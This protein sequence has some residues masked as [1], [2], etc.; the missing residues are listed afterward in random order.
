MR[1]LPVCEWLLF[2]LLAGM[3]TVSTLPGA[4]FKLNTDF[5]NYFLTASLVHEHYDTSRIYEWQW[6]E[7]QKDHRG[8]DQ[9]IVGMVPITPF[10]T[11]VVYPLT[12]F[13]ALT[14]KHC[15]IVFNLGLLVAAMYFLRS[16][17]ALPW[18]RIALLAAMNHTLAINFEYGQFYVLLLFLI[19]LACWCHVRQK[20]WWSGLLIGLATGI[21]IFP[22]IFLVYFLRKKDWRAFTGGVIGAASTGAV[23][24]MVFG[25][26][27]HRTYL[28]Q[29]LPPVLRGE[30]L[31]PYHLGAES[32]SSLLHRLFVYEP[33]SNP[34][35]ALHAAWMFAVLH[36]LLQMALAAP[37][38][39]LAVPGD[40][41]PRRVGLEWV[42]LLM[43]SLVTSTSPGDYLF[44]LLLFPACVLLERLL[45]LRAYWWVLAV[46]LLYAT[47]GYA[48]GTN[49][50]R[51]G[52][53]ALLGVPRLHALVALAVI[54]Y[55]MQRWLQRSEPGPVQHGPVQSGSTFAWAVA[56]GVVLVFSVVSN[57]RHQRGLYADYA[58]RIAAP[59]DVFLMAAPTVDG[60]AVGFVAMMGTGYHSVIQ[61]PG[62]TS[63]SE[64]S[65]DDVLG[66]TAAQGKWWVEQV[67]RESSV[68]AGPFPAST[69][70]QAEHP[71]ASAAGHWLAYLRED[72]GRAQVLRRDLQQP[73][74][75]DAVITPP[76]LNVTEMSLT[77]D[78]GLVFSAT[79]GGRT[80]LYF[81]DG[82]GSVRA[83][84]VNDTRYP[85]VS[86]DGHW[87]AYSELHGGN[88]NLWLR[89]LSSGEERR[90]TEAPCNQMESAWSSDSKSL[91]YASDCGRGL[92][93]TMLCK[94]RVV[95]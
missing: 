59:K 22:G 95:P 7:R 68:I 73:S 82:G 52:W 87:L 92:W 79:D 85:A 39:L 32:L 49:V 33:Y 83:M 1:W 86:P 60:D 53:L 64:V 91:I 76:Q 89:D 63:L 43:A 42:T 54:A 84:N 19:V 44:T 66:T 65:D 90:L 58:L 28:T 47:A 93:F 11:L 61:R 14:A 15:W 3:M 38:L 88:W 30:G 78:G 36:P 50:G 5:P 72:H 20:S 62:E 80:A 46:T 8:L 56:L 13:A 4:W 29:V 2:A 94:R 35:P 75:M 51:D 37:A 21:K 45:E 34:H 70:P 9:R 48:G 16:L 57:V 25:W 41:R 24:V 18:R 81:A 23:S 69:I 55:A 77:P 27:L 31:D 71:I 74:S 10:S 67:G 40:T 12:G 6:I 17:T 26:A